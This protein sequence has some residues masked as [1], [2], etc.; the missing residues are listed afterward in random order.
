MTSKRIDKIN[1]MTDE[2]IKEKIAIDTMKLDIEEI[3]NLKEYNKTVIELNKRVDR[4]NNKR[5]RLKK[6]IE[7]DIV[8]PKQKKSLKLVRNTKYEEQVDYVNT[9]KKWVNKLDI[10]KFDDGP[11]KE[12]IID[13]LN[14]INAF[15]VSKYVLVSDEE[16]EEIKEKD[17][18]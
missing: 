10:E 12:M 4:Y 17:E 5:K 8:E 18:K 3:D 14:D 16:L 11:E 7:G 2:L 1:S 9:T 6:L 13:A 15:K